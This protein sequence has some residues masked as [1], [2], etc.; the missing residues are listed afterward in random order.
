MASYSQYVY[1]DFHFEANVATTPSAGEAKIIGL[2]NPAC[3]TVGAAYFEITGATFRAVTYDVEKNTTA[4]NITWN[5]KGET[6]NGNMTKFR[7][8]WTANYVKFYVGGADAPYATHEGSDNIPNVAL[9]IDINNG[10]SDNLDI[11][12][13]KFDRIGT[14]IS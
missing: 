7:I 4:T 5:S 12:W 14:Y 11:D 9:A 1:G 10:D 6:W 2:R 3:P 8:V 13:I